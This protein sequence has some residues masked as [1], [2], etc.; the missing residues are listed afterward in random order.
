VLKGSSRDEHVWC[1][2]RQRC[3]S[4][5]DAATALGER[6]TVTVTTLGRDYLADSR[7]GCWL[8]PTTEREVLDDDDEGDNSRHRDRR[9]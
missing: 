9:E 4:D 1:A 3:D 5:H 6:R 2:R 8:A 7:R